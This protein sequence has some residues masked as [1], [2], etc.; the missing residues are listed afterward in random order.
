MDN[1]QKSG[2][3]V[4]ECPECSK[5]YWFRSGGGGP[6]QDYEEWWCPNC[7]KEIGREKTGGVPRTE[8][9]SETEEQEWATEKTKR[10]T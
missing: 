4:K 1:M 5:P 2:F 9:L 3:W 8:K 7:G 6:I 10:K